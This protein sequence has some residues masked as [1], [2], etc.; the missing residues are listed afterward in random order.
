MRAWFEWGTDDDYDIALRKESILITQGKRKAN[1]QLS[2]AGASSGSDEQRDGKI[3]T[4]PLN[5]D[6]R[7]AI[8][9]ARLCASEDLVLPEINCIWIEAGKKTKIFSSNDAALCFANCD[10]EWKDGT[11]FPLPLVDAIAKLK[12]DTVIRRDRIFGIRMERGIL[13]AQAPDKAWDAFPA[14][15]VKNLVVA[16]RKA[17]GG[18]EIQTAAFAAMLD[19]FGGY[20]AGGSKSDAELKLSGAKGK[21]LNIGGKTLFAEF[22]DIADADVSAP[23]ALAL[24]LPDLSRVMG[25]LKGRSETVKVVPQGKVA[26]ITA[27]RYEFIFSLRVSFNE[28]AS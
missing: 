10:T 23:V 1:L 21:S 19:T 4:I 22:A 20:L 7:D 17:V 14:D 18:F 15:R 26:H 25:F 24:G 13:W 28:T 8:V 9:C 3:E 16:A 27:G 6:L 12:V 5:D 2:D 11:A